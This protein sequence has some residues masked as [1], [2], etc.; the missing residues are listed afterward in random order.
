MSQCC[1]WVGSVKSD[2]FADVVV[3]LQHA[4]IT[5]T[6]RETIVDVGPLHATTEREKTMRLRHVLGIATLAGGIVLVFAGVCRHA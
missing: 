6:S 1:Y 4:G 5:Y 3:N 2:E